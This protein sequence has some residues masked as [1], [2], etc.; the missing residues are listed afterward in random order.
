MTTLDEFMAIDPNSYMARV[1]GWRPRTAALKANYD[2]YKRWAIAPAGTYWSGKTATAAQDGAAD[3][4]KGIDNADDTTE[5][6]AKLVTATITYEVIKPLTNGQNIV[7]NALHQGV[8]VSQDFTMT[9]TPA[10]GESEESIARNRKIVADA[11]RELQQYVAQWEKGEATLKTQTDA[12]RETMLSR[13]NPK[14]AFA[15][16]RK[17]LR[18]ATAPKPGDSPAT[19]TATSGKPH[20]IVQGMQDL[21][22]AGDTKPAGTTGAET[23]ADYKKWYPKD[24]VPVGDKNVDPSKLGG[25][26]AL[27]GVRDNSERTPQPLQRPVLRPE[28]V[29]QFKTETR[30]ALRDMKVPP[31]QIEA[32][33]NAA[34]QDAQTPHFKPDAPSASPTDPKYISRDFGEQFNR[35]TNGISDSATKTV[36]GQ[37]EQAKILTG[38][39]GPGAPGVAEA[40]KQVGLGAIQQ[41]HELTTD[42]L[43]APK[44]GIEQAKDFYNNPS[45]FIGKNIIHG[46]EALAGGV[47]G[48]EAAAGARGL[49]GDLTGAEGHAITHGI[50][51]AAPGHHQPPVGE[52]HTPTV[53]DH[54]AP[55]AGDHSW[56]FA[57]DSNGHY[58]PGS[59]P[60]YEQLRDLTQTDP[61][62]AHFWSGRDAGGIGV[63]PDGS[64]IAERI[65]EGVGGG[66][67]ETTLVK[68]GV[69]P[70]PVWNRHDPASVQFWED[71]SRAY[72]ENTNGEVTAVIGSDLR[73]GNI[74]QTVEI[75]RLMENPG[76][77]KIVQIDPDTGK[78]TVIFSRDK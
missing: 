39:A 12:A 66:T 65:A 34:I 69:D 15:D 73:P 16:G 55:S 8:S 71:A 36:D 30:Q 33:V 56:D 70:L 48:G 1:E 31:D 50:D 52:H 38:Q 37:I 61:N 43:A 64:G 57:V 10:E 76:V 77:T 20:G 35:F 19:V 53:G 23:V 3:D 72:A 4:C 51:D 49:L 44:M 25:M 68:N 22:G 17:I 5:D 32:R 27:G 7:N 13:I 41:A 9:Y 60:S 14:A 78:S 62:T 21:A 40:W 26:G 45:E 47:V 59:L 18:D 28:Q 29:E 11:Q 2:D 58:V 24:T 6:A 75:P 67:L 74:W 42:P 63:G 54:S 46:T